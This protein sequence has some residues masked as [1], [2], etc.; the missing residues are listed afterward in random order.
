MFT[1][2]PMTS[3]NRVIP[4][5]D[6]SPMMIFARCDIGIASVG[7]RSDGVRIFSAIRSAG[8]AGLVPTAADGRQNRDRNDQ[9]NDGEQAAQHQRSG[10]LSGSR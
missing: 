10:S 4:A 8:H 9:G 3:A 6:S 5:T 7:L 2:R 1:E